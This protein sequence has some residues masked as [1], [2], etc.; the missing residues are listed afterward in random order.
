MTP[1]A[2][3]PPRTAGG[4]PVAPARSLFRLALAALGLCLATVIAL[5]AYSRDLQGRVE[6]TTLVYQ[7]TRS[8]LLD[9]TG[10]VPGAADTVE[11]GASPGRAI[12]RFDSVADLTADDPGQQARMRAI[13][14]IAGSWAVA[15]RR[16]AAAAPG[17]A[18]AVES[19]V[20]AF[21]AEEQRLYRIRSSRFHRAQAITILV[22]AVE[23]ALVAGLLVMY[24]RRTLGELRAAAD[25]QTRLD[26]QALLLQH[27]AVDLEVANHEL[28]EVVDRERERRLAIPDE[29][30]REDAPATIDPRFHAQKMEALGRLAGGVAHD[31]NNSLA[32]INAYASM[33][34]LS[35]ELGEVDRARANEIAEA[36]QRA[37]ALTQR[38]L[39]FGR[40]QATRARRFDVARFVREMVPELERRLPASIRLD[41]RIAPTP[42]EALIDAAQLEQAVLALVDN[43]IHAMPAGGGLAIAAEAADLDEASVGSHGPVPPGRYAVLTVSDTG[44]GMDDATLSRIFEPYFTTRDAGNGKGLGLASVYAIVKNA[45]GYT[46]VRS[47]PAGGTKVTVYVPLA[48][49]EG[50]APPEPSA[51]MGLDRGDFARLLLVEDD[52][53]LRPA[54][55]RLLEDAGYTVVQAASGEAALDILRAQADVLDLVIMDLVLPG[56]GGRE[57]GETVAR[58][59][60]A[61]RVLFT[62][63]YTDDDGL[64]RD[65]IER[66]YAFV[67]KPFTRERLLAAI[68]QALAAV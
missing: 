68:D 54:V 63:G 29:P 42:V 13:R 65:M 21:L 32:V 31:F 7:T 44:V 58:E 19:R 45:G 60:P 38:L 64:R 51:S 25:L 53:Q 27:Q 16:N 39:A 49:D 46:S 14:E 24:R 17:L 62:S 35:P 8:A 9:L 48:L 34:A 37:T 28:R 1:P 6:H 40:R 2:S 12:A 3:R 66:G 67:Q 43:A 23:L 18:A 47:A 57:L 26:E 10:T 61:L 55:A 41:A 11:S 33:L 15:A 36:V 22:V 59:Y 5:T 52:E 30:R 4:L 20:R 50:P 56:V